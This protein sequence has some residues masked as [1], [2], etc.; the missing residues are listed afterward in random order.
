MALMAAAAATSAG[1]VAQS[2]LDDFRAHGYPSPL[3]AYQRLRA[4]PVPGADAPLDLRWR[5][6]AALAEHA[7]RAQDKDVAK[8]ART[9]LAALAQRERC[10]PCRIELMLLDENDAEREDDIPRLRELLRQLEALPL[11][12]DAQLRF[13]VLAAIA[14]GHD[15][16][17]EYDLAIEAE[18]KAGEL[19]AA[20]D[21]PA[22]HAAV[23]N[24]L[25]RSN[26]GRGDLRRAVAMAAEG[27]VLAER[28]GFTFMMTLLRGNEAYARSQMKDEVGPRRAAL[29]DA[30]RLSRSVPGLRSVELTALTNIANFHNDQHEYET[31]VRFAREGEA[32]SRKLG[33]EIGRAFAIVNLGVALVHLGQDEQGLALVRESVDIAEKMGLK[34]ET[35]TLLEQLADA[36]EQAGRPREALQ[37]LRRWA[38]LKDELTRTQRDQAVLG[39]QE[40][41]SAERKTRE[42]ERLQLENGKRAAEVAARASQQRLWAAVAVALTL[43]A[44]MLAQWLSQARRR[45]QALEADNAKLSEQSSHDPL[46]GAFNRRHCQTL[47]ARYARE[48]RTVGLMV[49]DVDFFKKVNDTHGH[50][51]GDAVLIEVSRRLQSLL[52]DQDAVVRWGGEEFVLV[53]PGTP[54]EALPVVAERVLAAIASDEFDVGEG[55]RLSV[56]MSGGAVAWPAWPGQPWEDALHVADL[57]LYLSKSGG[58]HRVN[59]LSGVAPDAPHDRLH[60]D[61]GAARDAG[62]VTLTTVPGAVRSRSPHTAAA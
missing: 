60:H 15:T 32:L 31:A 30:L 35:A 23:F 25:V 13:E 46:T 20:E 51:A 9:E 34:Q 41:Y 26:A 53:L 21:R 52:R 49:L 33:I 24:L 50:A 54:A 2:L 44:L 39:L 5:F 3:V 12:A 22:D 6:Q 47:M 14:S 11:P 7:A 56:Q 42:I 45:A 4:T 36:S 27:Y 18:V 1:E 38:K 48:G 10:E 29:Y 17:G 59:C 55:V 40:Q 19:A 57:A 16:V 58:R 28:I 43:A 62:Q 37:A 8:A 61:L